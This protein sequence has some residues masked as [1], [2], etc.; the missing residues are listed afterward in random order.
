MSEELRARVEQLQQERDQ[1]Q[2]ERELYW[3][4]LEL[5][6]CAQLRPLLEEALALIVKVTGAKKGLLA[7]YEGANTERPRLS[8]ARSYSD[9]EVEA[10]HEKISRGVI[11]RAMATGEA[12]HLGSAREDPAFQENTSVLAYNIGAVLC[13]PIF[14]ELPL[15][16][17]YLQDREDGEGFSEEDRRRAFAF[18]RHLAPYVDRLFT[19]ERERKAGDRTLPFRQRLKL[20]GLVGRSPALAELLQ[21]VES[22]ARFEA[23]ILLTGPSGTGKTALARAIHQNSPRA[24]KPFLE[25]NCAAIPAELFES[26][27]FG[28]LPGAHSTATRKIPGKLSAAQGGTLFLDEIGELSLPLQSK[29]LQL[30][31]SREYFPLGA[32]KPEKAD[33]RLITATNQNLQEAI[34]RKGFRED[35]YYRLKVLIIRVPPLA[36]RVEDI[37][38]LFEHFCEET[39]TRYGIP[40]LAISSAALHAAAEVEWP[41]NV[42]QLAHA[43]EAAIIRASTAGSPGVETHH[44]FQEPS[45]EARPLTFQEATRRFQRRFLLEA[46]EATHWN[47]TEAARRIDLTRVHT[48]NLLQA[49]DLKQLDPRKKPAT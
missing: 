22:A 44:L 8:I 15:G 6:V 32:T 19:R 5:G 14:L 2:Q 23:S 39:C 16:V 17:L 13:V 25:L 46:L 3:R 37:P 26:E 49:F 40:P 33:I 1:L 18:A 9:P 35:L 20:D 4:L 45:P 7:L 34:A 24:D 38:L 48:S 28:A 29:L 36:E 27:L 42:R 43:V 41:G 31:Q 12:I 47:V 11:A 30:L 21:Q 10:L